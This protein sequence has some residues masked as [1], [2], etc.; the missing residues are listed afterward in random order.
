MS[1]ANALLCA[2]ILRSPAA[3]LPLEP[4]TTLLENRGPGD[5]EVLVGRFSAGLPVGLGPLP[6]GPPAALVIPADRSATP[7][8]LGVVGEGSLALCRD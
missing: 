4:G 8:R 5:L 3:G 6:P 1:N 7:W 2:S